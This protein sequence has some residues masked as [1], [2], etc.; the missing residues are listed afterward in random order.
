[1]KNQVFSFG[2]IDEKVFFNVMNPFLL[3]QVSLK[4]PKTATCSPFL[5]F[6]LQL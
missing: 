5:K 4:K 2:C 3:W 6:S 1:M